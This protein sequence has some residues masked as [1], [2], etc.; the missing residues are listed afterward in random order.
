M[1]ILK[2][3]RTFFLLSMS[4]SDRNQVMIMVNIPFKLTNVYYHKFL[5][6]CEKLD[7]LLIPIIYEIN[8]DNENWN[9][10]VNTCLGHWN[11]G[12]L[13][14]CQKEAIS[15]TNNP[16]MN[17]FNNHC[18]LYEECPLKDLLPRDLKDKKLK[19]M[20][21]SRMIIGIFTHVETDDDYIYEI[22]NIISN[23]P[24]ICQLHSNLKNRFIVTL[25][26]IYKLKTSA[27]KTFS[28]KLK[29][30]QLETQ[31][32]KLVNIRNELNK[33]NRNKMNGKTINIELYKKL[34]SESKIIMDEIMKLVG[35]D[36]FNED[37]LK[38]LKEDLAGCKLL[39][40]SVARAVL[41]GQYACFRST[42][43]KLLDINKITIFNEPK[44]K[45]KKIAFQL[46]Q[47]MCLLNVYY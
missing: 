8:K 25:F 26:K 36:K 5:Q 44:D 18:Q 4:S 47:T 31:Y 15:E 27:Y 30:P 24:E 17:T 19:V 41:I 11:Q 39:L 12:K 20:A 38:N 46:G 16:I 7:T 21:S 23:I 2:L 10:P 34:Y 29:D 32:L 22:M 3:M 13:I 45:L 28:S 33:F 9:K 6:I 35:E 43:L 14:W 40:R 37:F 42:F 1:E